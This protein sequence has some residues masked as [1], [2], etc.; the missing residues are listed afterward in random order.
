MSEFAPANKIRGRKKLLEGNRQSGRGKGR[1]DN[2]EWIKGW[3]L[4]DTSIK[5]S[6]RLRVFFTVKKEH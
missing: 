5:V 1:K 6:I 2:I 4:G 3:V